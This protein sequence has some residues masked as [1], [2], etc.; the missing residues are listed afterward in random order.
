MR[1]ITTRFVVLVATL[2]VAPLVLYGAVSISSLRT[3]SRQSVIDGNSN[4]AARAAEQLEQYI[5][6]QVGILRSIASN[7]RETRLQPRQ[8]KQILTNH[9]LDFE[10]FRELTLFDPD[11]AVVATSKLGGPRLT[12]PASSISE[13]H[14]A[15]ITVDDD[16][17]PTTTITLP[18]TKG[19]K[20]NGW[21]SGEVNLEELWRLVDRVRVGRE[22]FALIVAAGGQLIAHGN[23]NEKQRVA[24]AENFGNHRLIARTA[25]RLAGEGSTGP[26][27]HGRLRLLLGRVIHS[28]HSGADARDRGNRGGTPRGAGGDWG[29]R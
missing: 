10:G 5:D 21:L 28:T 8:Q 6:H 13:L 3:G 1:T 14:V 25:A 26:G 9:V 11:G 7:I 19:G 23:P 29:L 2:A 15:P 27:P 22:G 12:A 18:L 4:V 24:A 20:A 17:L 16:F